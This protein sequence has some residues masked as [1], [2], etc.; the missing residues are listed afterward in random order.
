MMGKP[1]FIIKAGTMSSRD[2]RRIE[3]LCDVVVAESTMPGEERF[4]ETVFIDADAK[5]RAAYE[6][7]RRIK[8]TQAERLDKSTLIKWFVDILLNGG[9]IETVKQVKS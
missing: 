1:L 2:I 9:N 6:L 5:A 7:F 8:D 3:K 4:L